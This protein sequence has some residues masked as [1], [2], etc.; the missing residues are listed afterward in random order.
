M[1]NV[2][3]PTKSPYIV[4]PPNTQVN[5]PGGSIT[6]SNGTIWQ[7]SSGEQIEYTPLGGAL[8][9]EKT[10]ANVVTLL[11]DGTNLNQLNGSGDWWTQPLQGGAGIKLAAPPAGYAKPTPLVAPPAPPHAASIPGAQ[12]PPIPVLETLWDAQGNAWTLPVIGGPLYRNGVAL[13]AAPDASG[14][15]WVGTEMFWLDSKGAW[16]TI[17]LDG[18]TSTPSAFIPAGYITIA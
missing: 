13:P 4:S 16:S 10:S 18:L 14:L 1:S 12:L 8:T 17:S 15:Y 9:V 6:D 7:I 2:I 3:D 5:G 11:W